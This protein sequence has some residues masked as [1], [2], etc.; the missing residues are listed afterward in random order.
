MTTSGNAAEQLGGR[1][2]KE[3]ITRSVAEGRRQ[4]NLIG[5][6]VRQLSQ[7]LACGRARIAALQ[8]QASE[9]GYE[10][11]V[12]VDDYVNASLAAETRLNATWKN[13]SEALKD[14]NIVLFGRTGAG[15]ST[16]I[17]ALSHGDGQSV[18]Q[19]ESDWTVDVNP[20]RWQD[21]MLIDT[22]G[23][24]GWGRTQKRADLE[25]KAHRAVEAADIVLLCFDTQG[26]Q[27]SEFARVAEWVIAYGK[28]AIAVINNS[29]PEWRNPV[30]QG[31]RHL[32]VKHSRTMKQH[33]SNVRDN[34]AAEGLGELPVICLNSR[35]ALLSRARLPY[36][37]PGANELATQREKYGAEALLRWSN[38]PALEELIVE[39]LS[40][41]AASIRLG[42]LTA[43]LRG[44]LVAIRFDLN[45]HAQFA[46]Y[47]AET[48][49]E[50][51]TKL[52][53]LLGYPAD[54]A[55]RSKLPHAERGTDVLS[56]QESLRGGRYTVPTEGEFDEHLS[57]LID[58]W[59]GEHRA[60]TMR[61]AEE[62]VIGAFERKETV[63]AAKF[64][65]IYQ[66]AVLKQA[67]KKVLELAADY[68]SDRVDVQGVLIAFDAVNLDAS[69]ATI[70][71]DTGWESRW[72]SNI[73]RFGKVAVGAIGVISAPTGIGPVAAAVVSGIVMDKMQKSSAGT[74]EASRS[75]ARRQ[76]L[77][78]V[79][80]AVAKTFDELHRQI[81]QAARNYR[82]ECLLQTLPPLLHEAG[83]CRAVVIETE[84]LIVEVDHT[85]STLKRSRPVVALNE[86]AQRIEARHPAERSSARLIWAGEDWID[87][88]EGLLTAAA[89]VDATTGNG[90]C[91]WT[92]WRT[93]EIRR[94]PE[95]YG[96]AFV[97]WAESRL[98]D[99]KAA[100]PVLSD[101]RDLASL[102]RPSITL[103]GDYNAG[104]TTFI[105][106]I[107]AEAGMSVP[108]DI[109]IRADPTTNS[110][111]RYNCG[112][113]WLIDT[114]GF[115]SGRAGDDFL[116]Q[117]ALPEASILVWLLNRSILDS[118]IEHLCSV[119]I[120]H[121][122]LGLPGKIGRT[123]LVL[124]RA[125]DL[126]G[127]PVEQPE[128]FANVVRR[129]RVELCNALV[130]KGVQ[131]PVEDIFIVAADPFALVGDE[132]GVD[133]TAFDLHRAWDGM[134]N[135]LQ[136]LSNRLSGPEAPYW[137][138][139][140]VLEGGLFRLVGADRQL[141]ADQ[142]EWEIQ[143]AFLNELIATLDARCHEAATFHKRIILDIDRMLEETTQSLLEDMWGARNPNEL[144]AAGKRLETW[145]ED[146]V[147]SQEVARWQNRWKTELDRWFERATEEVQR[148]MESRELRE[149]VISL[150]KSFDADGLGH[151]AGLLSEGG[152][153]VSSLLQQGVAK[154]GERDVVYGIGKFFNFKFKP[155]GATKIAGR[156]AKYGGRAF[157]VL[158]TFY[159]I[160][161]WRNDE[162]R[163]VEVE[164]LRKDIAAA[165]A[166]GRD[167]IRTSMLG[168]DAQREGVAA[169]LHTCRASLTA[170]RDDL[171]AAQGLNAAR[172]QRLEG[173]RTAIA[174]VIANGRQWLE[175]CIKGKRVDA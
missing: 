170:V 137:I 168:D 87:D 53:K 122:K 123:I 37:G 173:E 157:V 65:S 22:P 75:Q 98:R 153:A 83:T 112:E 36:T 78:E 88:P 35:R 57:R 114:P 81:R 63:E 118:T 48:V 24:N 15:K 162:K 145:W 30:R 100:Q 161:S 124:G 147:F 97:A 69:A 86:A 116:A 172:L 33:E 13:R 101:M 115:R 64:V 38:L 72:S 31:R 128:E 74:A 113:A 76:A 46:R 156:F 5:R 117:N 108:D 52:L 59:L 8:T 4:A 56:W 105:R 77:A 90:Q 167:E 49:D 110:V 166:A 62:Q 39:A 107:L 120:E 54:G 3:A 84:R 103:V 73:L 121:K 29:H 130:S 129:K 1:G 164:A 34:L 6:D 16:L 138:D 7:S 159:E 58:T 55:V 126:G 79:R 47:R 20:V 174:E 96:E 44:D 95:R 67:S 11:R 25:A 109:E 127:D 140:P 146:P 111:R 61:R 134:D 32:R 40:S 136:A 94:D 106:R 89:D 160:W 143:D 141:Q 93:P 10:Q 99:V 171:A 68:L 12:L 119:L 70:Q 131:I 43:S 85:G 50:E 102:D 23:I 133:A 71:G 154:L 144:Q 148:T 92:P 51:I 2:L 139:I 66:H 151:Q 27:V 82:D 21:C 42:M 152:S 91:V 155:W 165:V 163:A 132:S 149:T 169:Y 125:D 45:T 60:S 9:L 150:G 104:K 19:G 80:A 17:E 18:S 175:V 26:Q 142:A 158:T 135:L 28:P 14:F 41:D